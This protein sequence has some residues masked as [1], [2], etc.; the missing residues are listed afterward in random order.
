MPALA[1]K[2]IRAIPLILLV[3]SLAVTTW[4]W[5]QQTQTVAARARERFARQVDEAQSLILA[6]MAAYEVLLHGARGLFAV[7][8]SVDPSQW[9]H[10]VTALG[11]EQRYPGIDALGFIAHV[12]S[13]ELGSF[14][15]AMRAA[16]ASEYVVRPAARRAEYFP[17]M[18]VQPGGRNHRVLGF[19]LG[20]DPAQRT[21]AEH[22]RD[23]GRATL[24]VKI[25]LPDGQPGLLMLV[26]VYRQ[27]RPQATVEERRAALVGWVYAPLRA[28]DLMRGLLAT[29]SA[30]ID[31]EIFDGAEVSPG[32]LLY[33]SNPT[34]LP[35]GYQPAFSLKRTA[36][37]GGRLWTLGFNTTSA[38]DLVV[39]S[40]QPFLVMM[41]GIA[42]S[43]LLFAV[44]LSMVNTRR[45][46]LALAERMTL[47]LRDAHAELEIRVRQ[48]TEELDRANMALRAA[49]EAAEVA[50]GAKSQFL[51]SMSHELRTP[52]NAIIGFSEVLLDPTLKVTPEEEVQFLADVLHSGKHLLALI[53]EVLDLAKI[54]AGRMELHIEPASLGE[55]LLTIQRTMHALALKKAIDLQVDS[56]LS[57]SVPMD[58]SR[59][60]QVLLNLVGNAIKFTPEAGRVWIRARVEARGVRV[61]VGDTGPGIPAEEQQRIFGEFQQLTGD[62]ADK[63]EGTGLGLA[64]AKRFVEMHGGTLW[65]E[66]ESGKGSRFLF[67]LPMRTGGDGGG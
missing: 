21:T 65:V 52:L 67:T 59:I 14:E 19:D 29:G 43:A 6:R 64:L 34:A 36:E 42:A 50:S 3:L 45:R 46:A 23:S 47:E 44:T 58:A 24:S 9:E 60:R 12:R 11:I 26:P 49:K 13:S 16:G 33:D 40:G 61:E 32:S 4:L 30:E 57:G 39:N 56:G 18:L 1:Q 20:A 51:A 10:Y 53:N 17:V 25:T 2:S 37:V 28:N 63:P 54:E 66:S 27:D 15:A 5:Q 48:R 41:G 8:R 35:R 22:A 55:L 38:F 7:S 62:G 31:F